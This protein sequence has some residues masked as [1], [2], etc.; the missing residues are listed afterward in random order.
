MP[1]NC[2]RETWQSCD[3]FSAVLVVKILKFSKYNVLICYLVIIC[4]K[5]SDNGVLECQLSCQFKK[6]WIMIVFFNNLPSSRI[7]SGGKTA[8]RVMCLHTW[9]SPALG[10]LLIRS[11]NPDLVNNFGYPL[12]WFEPRAAAWPAMLLTPQPSRLFVIMIYSDV[13]IHV[14]HRDINR[15]GFQ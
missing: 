4:I 13:N 3:D 8:D 7:S 6:K 1:E 10:R 15:K 12:W 9:R 2:P 14:S 5:V 11:L